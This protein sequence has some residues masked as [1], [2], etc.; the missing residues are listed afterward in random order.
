[1][2]I[3]DKIKEGIE[4]LVSKAY[5]YEGEKNIVLDI[6]NEMLVY[7]ASKGAVIQVEKEIPNYPDSPHFYRVSAQDA[8]KLAQEDMLK[9]HY[10]KAEPL[11]L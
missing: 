7:L 5:W 4:R 2:T 3:Q 1:M 10:V 8:Y 11:I 6:T 9:A